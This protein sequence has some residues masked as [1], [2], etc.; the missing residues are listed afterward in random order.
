MLKESW[1][2]AQGAIDELEKE[3][4]VY[5]S[6]TARKP[7]Q[8]KESKP[9]FV[10]WNEIKPHEPGGAKVDDGTNSVPE[11]TQTY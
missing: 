3:G 11:Q 7:E 5:I 9:V 6:R 4:E 2:D 1:K 8:K 10:F